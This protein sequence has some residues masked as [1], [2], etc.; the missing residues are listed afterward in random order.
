MCLELDV[1][2]FKRVRDMEQFFGNVLRAGELAAS[3]VKQ[4]QSSQR[5][6]QI[7]GARKFSRQMFGTFEDSANL[8]SR[9]A[10]NTHQRW[11]KLR[12]D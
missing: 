7:G 6:R 3:C 11:A 10:M 12:Q 1:R 4:P 9:P 5:R 8:W 2:I